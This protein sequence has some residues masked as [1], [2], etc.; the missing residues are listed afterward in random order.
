MIILSDEANFVFKFLYRD[1]SLY[2]AHWHCALSVVASVL[3][4]PLP[5]VTVCVFHLFLPLLQEATS[6]ELE[7]SFYDHF[8]LKL[9][10][11]Q[12]LMTSRGTQ[13]TCFLVRVM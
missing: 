4:L 6:D 8:Y 9:K 5:A 12:I 11:T 7:E 2:V 1:V 13:S 10:D 3:P